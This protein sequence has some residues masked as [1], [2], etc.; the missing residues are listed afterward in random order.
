MSGVNNKERSYKGTPG[1]SV[2]FTVLKKELTD[3]IRDTRS[4]IM[5]LI[6]LLVFP[7]LFC[8][9]DRQ[10]SSTEKK[11]DRSITIAVSSAEDLSDLSERLCAGKQIEF[12]ESDDI[13]NAL[14]RGQVLLGIDLTQEKP[15]IVYD[16]NSVRSCTA[17]AEINAW[18]ET[19]KAEAIVTEIIRLG[20]DPTVI[21]SGAFETQDLSVY[22]DQASNA[23]LVSLVP[24]LVI[25][26]IFSGG[27]AVTLD[28]F[29][30]EKERGTLECLMM[31]KASQISI[32]VAKMA[33]VLVFCIVSALLSMAGCFLAITANPNVAAM[34][35]SQTTVVSFK[36]IVLA[37]GCSLSFALFAVAIMSYLCITS[38]SVKE[39]Q[40]KLNV[41]TMCPAL[42]GGITMYIELSDASALTYFVPILNLSILLKQIFS[43]VIDPAAMAYTVLSS[44]LY[45]VLFALMGTRVF[46]SEKLWHH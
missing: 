2:F 17:L 13:A 27:T 46:A 43:N 45:S 30:G 28:T 39:G 22:T 25:T 19:E 31:T 33:A 14:R 4:L 15:V 36:T 21:N 3:A 42:I 12:M 6:P 8:V 41:L 1:M 5:I 20:G 34:Y 26:F 18:M 11:V 10:I 24:M 9:L 29:C 32:L 38:R 16:Q 35:G 7:I 23:L 37:M 40:M 44:L